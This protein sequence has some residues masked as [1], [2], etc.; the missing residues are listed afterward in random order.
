MRGTVATLAYPRTG[1]A[2]SHVCFFA[3]GRS[4]LLELAPHTAASKMSW[5]LFSLWCGL[6][7]QTLYPKLTERGFTGFATVILLELIIGSLLMISLGII[8]E[9]LARI[10]RRG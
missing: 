1:L 9:Y 8:G 3:I 6:G 10:L 5:R 4:R 2:R 7:V